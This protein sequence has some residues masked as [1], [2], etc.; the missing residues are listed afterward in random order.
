VSD[1]PIY[2]AWIAASGCRAKPES[3]R[4]VYLH[5]VMARIAEDGLTE[6]A[7]LLAA[8]RRAG[9]QDELD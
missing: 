8:A 1:S 9:P 6:R 3:R 4:R 2:A 5:W 7:D